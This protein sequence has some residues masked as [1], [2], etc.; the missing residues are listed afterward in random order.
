MDNTLCNI[1]ILYKSSKNNFL[2]SNNMSVEIIPNN[3]T[4]NI[5]VKTTNT[6]YEKFYTLDDFKRLSK[7]KIL[8]LR[9]YLRFTIY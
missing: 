5:L 4:I 8:H 6:I 2:Q 9:I 7:K 1:K 3:E